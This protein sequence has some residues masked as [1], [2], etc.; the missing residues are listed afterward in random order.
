MEMCGKMERRV[1]TKERELK[2]GHAIS[3]LVI[4]LIM[5]NVSFS[6]CWIW[7]VKFPYYSGESE[8]RL[9]Q[10]ASGSRQGETKQELISLL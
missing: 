8:H 6:L 7:M 1:G 4:V 9:K 5:L 3:I 10:A 2:S